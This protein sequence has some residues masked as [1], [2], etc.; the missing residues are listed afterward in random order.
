MS[1]LPQYKEGQEVERLNRGHLLIH[2]TAHVSS[3]TAA[4]CPGLHQTARERNKVLKVS[5]LLETTEEQLF[6]ST[7]TFS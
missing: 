4:S 7:T 3:Q 6:A 1:L 2:I 5:A